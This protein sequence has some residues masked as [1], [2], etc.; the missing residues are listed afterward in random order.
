MNQQIMVNFVLEWED[1]N[2][3]L[4]KEDWKTPMRYYFRY[5]LEHLVERSKFQENY[6]ILGDFK[7]NPL[8]KDSKE[9][10]VVCKK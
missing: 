9:F 8:E 2:G 7:G 1:E 3:K 4:M 10:I 5:E 6:N